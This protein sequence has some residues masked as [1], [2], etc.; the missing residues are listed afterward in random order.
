MTEFYRSFNHY[1]AYSC[2]FALFLIPKATLAADQIAASR[3]TAIVR[4]VEQVQ[5]AVVSVYVTFTEHV[6]RP[7]WERDP[8]YGFFYPRSSLVPLERTSSGSGLIVDNKGHVLTNDHVIGSK[9]KLQHIEITLQDGRSF[10]AD[11]IGSDTSFD[12]ALIKAQGDQLPVAPLGDSD[13]ILVGEWAIAIGNPFDVG[14]SVSV[15]VV[16]GIN[17][18][19]PQVQG[20]YYYRDLIQ[21]DASINP[22]NSG[23]PLINALG[24]VIGINS[25]IHTG[26]NN[27]IGSIGIG[28]A[29]PSNTAR[30]FLDEITRHGKV[31]RPWTGILRL[32]NITPRLAEGLDLPSTNGA[33]IVDLVPEGPSYTAGL[34]RWDA[35]VAVNDEKVVTAQQARSVL[36]SFRV[37]EQCTL[38]VMR[39]GETLDLTLLLTEEPQRP[40]RWY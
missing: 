9:R 14:V 38:T 21:T 33:L 17:R 29:I 6:Q 31:R 15:G 34:R 7:Y 10:S 13:D 40:G 28:F 1:W 2:I 11:Y 19:F 4:A 20:D 12:L 37:D 22:G 25:F 8:F 26:S 3:R 36:Q 30:S 23:G 5:P 16:S 18:N 39:D 35:L 24:E 32:Q 27:N